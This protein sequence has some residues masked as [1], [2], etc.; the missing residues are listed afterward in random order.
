M[1][2]ET[3]GSLCNGAK[4][5]VT[6][7]SEIPIDLGNND[8]T[9]QYLVLLNGHDGNTAISAYFTN[10]RVVCQNTLNAS[11]GNCV[12]KHTVRHTANA[13]DNLTEALK[14]MRVIEQ[15]AE[16]DKQ[17]YQRMKAQQ[18]TD[19]MFSHYLGNVFFTPEEMTNYKNGDAN[20][21]STRKKM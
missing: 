6:L 7:K 21:I 16:E 8:L 18:F 10:V 15:N 11:L 13:K 1:T 5:F 17:A 20:I 19:K 14:I 3:V 2:I 12:Q 4:V 9:E